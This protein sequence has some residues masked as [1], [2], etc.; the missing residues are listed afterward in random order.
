MVR[1]LRAPRPGPLRGT[2]RAS[3]TAVNPARSCGRSVGEYEA[4]GDGYGRRPPGESLLQSRLVERPSAVFEAPFS[5]SA[6]AVL[7]CGPCVQY[8]AAVGPLAAAAV[9]DVADAERIVPLIP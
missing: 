4:E 5:R 6:R 2:R 8:V 9:C 3:I 7:R 1:P